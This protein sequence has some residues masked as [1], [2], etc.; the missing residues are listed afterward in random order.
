M[1]QNIIE[2]LT[3]LKLTPVKDD[4]EKIDTK[5][6]FSSTAAAYGNPSKGIP[7]KE[8]TIPIGSP[9]GG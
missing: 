7:I 8:V 9:I 3:T 2:V 6:I 5:V 1:K 4:F